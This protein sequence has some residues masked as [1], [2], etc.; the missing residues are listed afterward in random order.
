MR[1]CQPFRDL[2]SDPDD[3]GDG[4]LLLAFESFIEWFALKKFHRQIGHAAV[5][6]D[7][8]GVAK[9]DLAGIGYERRNGYAWYGTWPQSLLAVEYPAWKKRL[10]AKSGR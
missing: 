5:F 2:P 6:A 3:F 7:R 1:G 10:A 9:P 8:D 4:E